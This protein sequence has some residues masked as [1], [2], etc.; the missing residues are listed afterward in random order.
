ME[1]SASAVRL[2]RLYAPSPAHLKAWIHAMA[3]G[4][5]GYR[6]TGGRLVSSRAI[7][8]KHLGGRLKGILVQFGGRRGRHLPGV[9][10]IRSICPWYTATDMVVF[11]L[12]GGGEGGDTYRGWHR[13]DPSVLGTQPQ[14]WWCSVCRRGG[15]LPGVAQIISICPWYTA[16]DMVVFSL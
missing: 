15:H 1:G 4:G 7:L 9:A 11:S 13:S 5:G 16:T 6:D 8:I 3:P 10:Q 12:W 14:I 2:A